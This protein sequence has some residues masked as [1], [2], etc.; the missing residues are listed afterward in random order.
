VIGA[1]HWL[2]WVVFIVGSAS[3]S[4]RGVD[5]ELLSF[6]AEPEHV[7]VGETPHATI[8]IEAR[9]PDGTPLDVAPPSLTTSTGTLGPLQRVDAG[10]WSVQF[11]PPSEAFPHVALVSA[12]IDTATTTAVGFIAVP[13]WGRGQTTVRTKPGSQVTVFVSGEH[14]GPVVADAAGDARVP[15]LVAPGP[16]HAVATSLD[17][18]GNESTR[19]IDLGVPGFN[20]LALIALD[21]VV[22]GDGTGRARLLAL[23]VDKKGAPLA[24]GLQLRSTSSIGTIAAPVAI[25]PG[26][27]E[28]VFTPGAVTAQQATVSVVLDGASLSKATAAVRVIG[29]APARAEVALSQRALSVDDNGAVSAAI[30]VF[31]QGG[32]PVPVG[33][34]RVD[35]DTGRIDRAGGGDLRRELSW[36]LPKTRGLKPTT[37]TLSVRTVAGDVIGTAA[38]ALL[39]GAIAQLQVRPLPAVVADG[40]AGVDV[41]VEATDAAGNRVVPTGVELTSAH[42]RIVGATIDV[43]SGVLRALYVPESRDEEG[44]V[45][46]V[47]HRGAVTTS[48]PLR[49]LPRPRPLLL[50]GPA[51]GSSFSGEVFAVGPELSLLVRLPILDGAV[52]GGVTL[53][54]LQGI[55]ALSSS[56]FAASRAFPVLLEGSWRPLLRP[57][58]G[59][60]LGL[61]AGL[62]V[63]DVTVDAAR[64]ISPAAAAAFVAGV[65]Q[66]LGP[67]ALELD[68]RLGWSVPFAPGP[69]PFGVG[70]VLGYRFGL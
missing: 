47:A 52:H 26:V 20:R 2:M 55:P 43:D 33:A 39:P 9:K 40:Q 45:D 25:A 69:V 59:L 66:R 13:L 67:G 3:A 34:V 23:A 19:T 63:S 44:V 28:L 12:T 1:W 38:L 54:A 31:D 10:V 57:Q 22:S 37:A 8:R 7:V 56:T 70:M 36:V 53:G 46:V 14:F 35:V 68:A 30:T 65:H 60:H 61:A 6:R 64:T 15:I 17:A 29:G 27:F 32:T 11:T 24:D 5:V 16:E 51:I 50:V 58:F 4:A 42:G 18:S 21:D 41:V 48:A 62:V 49:L